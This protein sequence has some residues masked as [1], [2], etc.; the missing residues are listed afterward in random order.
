MDYQ[1]VTLQASPPV[2]ILKLV[3]FQTIPH[4]TYQRRSQ[5]FQDL[6]SL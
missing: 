5:A 3:T 2:K 4:Q 1:V 6:I